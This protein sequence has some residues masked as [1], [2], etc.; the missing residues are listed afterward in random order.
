MTSPTA[1]NSAPTS[2]LTPKE[3]LDHWQ[4]HRRLT[5]RLIEKFPDDQLFTF[6]IGGM[7]SFG[8]LASEMIGMGAPSVRG[9]ADRKWDAFPHTK[10]TTK[11]ELLEQWDA[12]TEEID[13]R[14]PEI[15]VERFADVEKAFGMWEGSVISLLL[16][17][18]DNEVHH[19]GQGYVYLRALGV[20]PPPFWERT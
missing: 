10:A 16:Y 3:L 9:V 17:C 2:V 7:R 19:R 11:A 5:R 14:W 12:A 15:G 18:I 6:T 4:A 13:R 8:E 1:T 20:E